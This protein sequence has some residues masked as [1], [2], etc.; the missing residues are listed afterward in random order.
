MFKTRKCCSYARRHILKMNSDLYFVSLFYGF[1][2]LEIG[3]INLTF[4]SWFSI[5]VCA[6]QVHFIS[7]T[8]LTPQKETLLSPANSG[9]SVKIWWNELHWSQLDSAPLERESTVF[10]SQEEADF[11]P[12]G[13]L[14]WRQENVRLEITRIIPTIQLNNFPKK[15]NLL[16]VKMRQYQ[17]SEAEKHICKYISLF[18]VLYICIPCTYTC[19][20]YLCICTHKCKHI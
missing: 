14:C 6:H 12:S 5:L 20:L 4:I 17:F 16:M 9:C 2:R 13:S 18:T 7:V 1:Y 19:I 15:H 8:R 10:K 11:L 3:F